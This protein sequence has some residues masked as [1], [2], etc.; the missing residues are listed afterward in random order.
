MLL[1][2]HRNHNWF[3]MYF[4][5]YKYL[6]LVLFKSKWTGWINTNCRKSK[7]LMIW[8][9]NFK[10]APFLSSSF[11]WMPCPFCTLVA[12]LQFRPVENDFKNGIISWSDNMWVHYV[13]F[14]N[15]I[16]SSPHSCVVKSVVLGRRRRCTTPE[17]ASFNLLKLLRE[18]DQ[19]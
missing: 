7:N 4:I 6:H 15:N 5:L 14:N 2:L 10:T 16:L 3:D 17:K 9:N 11:F 18:L 19:P 1:N 13:F 8:T 12:D